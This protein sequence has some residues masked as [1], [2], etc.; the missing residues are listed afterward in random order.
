MLKKITLLTLLTITSSISVQSIFYELLSSLQSISLIHNPYKILGVS[1]WTPMKDIKKK[2]NEL[3]KK[4]HPDKSH[5][6]TREEF[7]LIQKSFENI[8]KRRKEN[9]ENEEEV[10]FYSAIKETIRCILSA[11]IV[12]VTLYSI[13]NIT[14]H[15][16]KLIGFP[17]FYIILVFTIINGLIPHWFSQEIYEYITSVILGIGLYICQCMIINIIFPKKEKID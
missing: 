4:Y 3:I 14:F 11:Q 16:Q 6:D 15:F 12:L 17:L 5:S 8:K 13:S 9:D 10:N 7:E 1:P 2:Y